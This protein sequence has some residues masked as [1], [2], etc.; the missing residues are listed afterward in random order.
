M[1]TRNLF[2]EWAAVWRWPLHSFSATNF[3]SVNEH[4]SHTCSTCL[5][6]YPGVCE[7]GCDKCGKSM[8]VWSPLMLYILTFCCNANAKPSLHV[9]VFINGS[10]PSDASWTPHP[11]ILFLFSEENDFFRPDSSAC[12]LNRERHLPCSQLERRDFCDS[13][14]KCSSFRPTLPD[15][16]RRNQTKRE[17]RQL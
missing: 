10:F 11:V 4:L 13:N 14:T 2:G 9:V 5:A 6:L 15:R 8:A 17:A 7:V 3:P 16:T 1:R 12:V